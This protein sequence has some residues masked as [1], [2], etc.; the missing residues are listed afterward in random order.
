MLVSQHAQLYADTKL[1]SSRLLQEQLA[2]YQQSFQLM[3]TQAAL[4]AGFAYSSLVSEIDAAD[5]SGLV[6]I[7][8]SCLSITFSVMAVTQCTLCGIKGPRLALLGP[9]GSVERGQ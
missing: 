7:A 4:F 5:F 1:Q 6:F 3:G 2:F 9:D 8:F